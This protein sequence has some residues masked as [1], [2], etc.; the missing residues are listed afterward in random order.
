MFEGHVLFPSS[1]RLAL[2][3]V[4]WD[5]FLL[6]SSP[7]GLG[8]EFF[9]RMSIRGRT[10]SS[11]SGSTN[12]PHQYN[13]DHSS[14]QVHLRSSSNPWALKRTHT[15][16]CRRT[17]GRALSVEEGRSYFRETP[18]PRRSSQKHTKT[19][20]GDAYFHWQPSFL[21]LEL[22]QARRFRLLSIVQ[23]HQ[24]PIITLAHH[25]FFMWSD[26]TKIT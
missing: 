17:F 2:G 10:D 5:S 18:R 15:C 3:L 22:H 19:A 12:K 9:L 20:D 4:A 26:T 1:H 21:M 7:L 25:M 16:S 24:Q 11:R 23:R 13:Q 14:L 8:K 6:S